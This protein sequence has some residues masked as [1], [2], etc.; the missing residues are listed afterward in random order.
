MSDAEI[1]EIVADISGTGTEKFE[2]NQ[3]TFTNTV[4][5]FPSCV[6]KGV[7]A[8][9]GGAPLMT[10]AEGA[11]QFS[12]KD[13]GDK[14]SEDQNDMFKKAE[15]REIIVDISVINHGGGVSSKLKFDGLSSSPGMSITTGK[16]TEQKTAIHKDAKMSGLNLSIYDIN[17]EYGNAPKMP[18]RTVDPNESTPVAKM[19]DDIISWLLKS[20]EVETHEANQMS[21][22]LSD[23]DSANRTV[24]S[25]VV[26]KILQNSPDTK[27][28][29][30]QIGE[31]TF[32]NGKF[33]DTLYTIL[34]AQPDFLQTL[35]TSILNTFI[36]QFVCDFDGGEGSAIIR[37]SQVNATPT[38][39]ETVDIISLNSSMGA[40][41]EL[42]L[43]QI[44]IA[45]ETLGCYGQQSIIDTSKPGDTSRA[46]SVNGAWPEKKTPVSGQTKLIVSPGWLVSTYT[47]APGGSPTTAPEGPAGEPAGR[48]ENNDAQD[49]IDDV[50]KKHEAP[51][52]TMPKILT[53]WAQKHYIQQA[54]QN[55]VCTITI[56]LDVGWGSSN[57]PLG[58]VYELTASNSKE[59]GGQ[60]IKLFDG[61]L[62]SVVHN[63]AIGTKQ[64]TASTNLTFSHI[65]GTKWSASNMTPKFGHSLADWVV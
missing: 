24:F 46:L 16:V 1:V 27:L 31:V 41:G 11:V 37:H 14:V 10:A 44:I 53:A 5:A 13:T 65:K 56:P 19:L 45:G 62:K 20:G 22:Y 26:S 55:H 59:G 50:K 39:N 61:Y 15:Q 7:R 12:L 4:N 18:K 58:E 6:I 9:E 33:F 35:L 48:D 28:N 43:G 38:R 63:V 51:M 2:A 3:I 34:T 40:T 25:N 29:F 8:S 60:D 47:A 36:F 52:K 57:K 49:G 30:K 64:G 42:P 54:L 32:D 23:T 21:D 17:N